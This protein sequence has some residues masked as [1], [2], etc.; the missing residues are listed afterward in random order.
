MVTGVFRYFIRAAAPPRFCIHF[1]YSYPPPYNDHTLERPPPPPA[2]P[3]APPPRR[4]HP[5]MLSLIDCLA[6]RGDSEQDGGGQS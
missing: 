1:R 2:P 5:R 4:L 3:P 6:T